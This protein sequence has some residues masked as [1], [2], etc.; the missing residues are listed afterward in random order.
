MAR[1]LRSLRTRVSSSCFRGSWSSLYLLDAGL[2]DSSTISD[3]AL[4]QCTRPLH[5]HGR[6]CRSRRCVSGARAA[7]PWRSVAWR[8]S[9]RGALI[10]GPPSVRW[11]VAPRR[12]AGTGSMNVFW[13][14]RECPRGGATAYSDPRARSNGRREWRWPWRGCGRA[15]R[16]L[17]S[18]S[19]DQGWTV[20]RLPS[21][22][23][24]ARTV[25]SVMSGRIQAEK[26]GPARR[27]G[28]KAQEEAQR[29][30]WAILWCAV[31]AE[32]ASAGWRPATTPTGN[33]IAKYIPC[34][35][36]SD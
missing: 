2:V 11:R 4:G 20:F 25:R 12:P 5:P 29:S 7:C 15:G 14:E 32:A 34:F 33:Y 27:M 6:S 16:R 26:S 13:R 30:S 31:S 1:C 17:R 24:V 23:G 9:K 19:P 3:S 28:L 36:K 18:S 22:P 10:H 8:R 35:A 21:T